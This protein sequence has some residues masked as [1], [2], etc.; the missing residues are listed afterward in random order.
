MTEYERNPV[1]SRWRSFCPKCGIE[2]DTF[3]ENLC[4]ACFRAGLTLLAPDRIAEE[5]RASVIVCPHCG[6]FFKGNERTD[7]EAVVEDAVRRAISKTHGPECPV[8]FREA[9]IAYDEAARSAHVCLRVQARIKDLDVVERAEFTVPVRR[10]ICAQCSRIAGGYYAAIVQIRADWRTPTEEELEAA[11]ELA[12]AVLSTEEFVTKQQLLK[13]GL[14]LYVSSAECGRRM[15]KAI[16]KHR[17][18]NYFESRKLY[19]R[20]GGRE[21]YRV[22]FLVRLPGY[23]VGD[24]IELAGKRIAVDKIVPGEGLEGV[25]LQTGERYFVPLRD[26]KRAKRE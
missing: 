13:E 2:T 14:D 3:F 25:E 11:V 6:G 22:T 18:G 4:E 8:E 1:R 20:R 23:T 9:E 24:V 15:A 19:G 21:V 26:Q 10:A 7:L 16:V 17:G 5:V 12:Y